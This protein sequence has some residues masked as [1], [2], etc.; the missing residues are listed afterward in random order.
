MK[1]TILLY[2]LI[3]FILNSQNITNISPNQAVQG[4]MLP[5]IISG[6][7][8]VFSGWSCWSNTGSL[9]DFR[10]SQWSGGNTIYGIPTSSTQNTL[11]GNLYVPAFQPTGIYNLEVYDCYQGQ[12]SIF[13][14]SFQIISAPPSWNCISNSCIDPG[15]GAGTYNSF[16][17]CMLSCGVNTSWNCDGIGN[18]YDPGNG[19]GFYNSFSL[20]QNSCFSTWNCISP[21]NC[22]E[23]FDGS[24]MYN[25]QAACV[26]SCV[27]PSWDCVSNACVD[28]GSG[29]GTFSSLSSCMIACGV[30][31]SWDCNPDPDPSIWSCTDPGD[32]SGTY[33]SELDCNMACSLNFIEDKLL[34]L[35]IYP[36]P[37]SNVLRIESNYSSLN[38]VNIFGEIVLTKSNSERIIDLNKLKPGTYFAYINIENMITIRRFTIVK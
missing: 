28:F 4:Q 1:R 17:N 21:Q 37:T 25:T 9:S 16:T 35:I 26:N 38:I 11:N 10:F 23:E 19:A 34:E 20:C 33:S 29:S 22:Q 7:N 31:P 2:I 18:C 27:L 12:W 6:N 36:N 3:P 15:N 30:T 32:G 8:F 5:L 14:N 13:P 24:G